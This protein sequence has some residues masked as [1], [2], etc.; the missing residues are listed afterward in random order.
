MKTLVR[1]PNAE[2]TAVRRNGGRIRN[3]HR[4]PAGLAAL[5]FACVSLAAPAGAQTV[6]V[7]PHIAVRITGDPA[8]PGFIADR[9]ETAVARAIEP[10]LPPGAVV[11]TGTILPAPQPLDRGFL[12]NFRVPVTI[13]SGAGGAAYAAT[14]VVDVTNVD[15]ARFTPRSLAFRDD[16]ERIVADGVLSR[17]TVTTGHPA[18]LYYYHENT[19][20]RRRFCVVLAAN[21]SVRTRVHLIGAS[22]GPNIDVMSVGHAVSKTFLARQPQNE[23]TVVTIAGGR[24]LVERDEIVA[25]GQGIVGSLDI[26][27]LDGGPVTVTVLAIPVTAGPADYLYSAKLPDDGHGRRGDFG[28]AD[29]GRWIVAFTVGGPDAAYT[30]GRRRPTLPNLDLADSGRD[31]GDYGVLQSI[32]FDLANPT[33]RPATVFLYEKPLGGVVRSSFRVNGQLV[34]VGCVRVPQRYAIASYELGPRS[35]ATLDVLTMTDGG[36][37]YPLEMGVT[38]TPPIPAAPAIRAADG[39]FPKPK[40]PSG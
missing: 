20:V 16:P 22:A 33:D 40:P 6:I 30:Y 2:S 5:A 9:I 12:T 18:R 31:Y 29:F 24:P 17:T 11:R 26:R 21:D 8:S 39:C 36:S 37:N 35:T 1:R 15:L 27:V 14:T 28:L 32:T 4:S 7:P 13:E 38:T 10:G 23:G 3:R 34:E 25:P 19:G